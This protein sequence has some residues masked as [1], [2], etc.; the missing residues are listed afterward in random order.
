[1]YAGLEGIKIKGGEGEGGYAEI[2]D[3]I[4][5]GARI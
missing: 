5:F 4:L 2:A 3:D 1:M